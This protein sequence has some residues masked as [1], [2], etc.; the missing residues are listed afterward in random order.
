MKEILHLMVVDDELGEGRREPLTAALNLGRRT[1][2][3]VEDAEAGTRLTL[4]ADHESEIWTY[5]VRREGVYQGTCISLRQTFTL[6]PR[7]SR[8]LRFTVQITDLE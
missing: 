5:P 2:L 1:G 7:E 3:V 4:G 6:P 8:R